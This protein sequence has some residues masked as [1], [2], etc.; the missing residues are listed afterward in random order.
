MLTAS[1]VTY[2]KLTVMCA[3]GQSFTFHRLSSFMNLL[4]DTITH[5]DKKTTKISAQLK[6][7]K[8]HLL[9]Q[10]VRGASLI[11]CHYCSVIHIFDCL[12]AGNLQRVFPSA[13][14]LPRRHTQ[15]GSAHNGLVLLVKKPRDFGRTIRSPTHSP[16]KLHSP[17]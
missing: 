6:E 1:V 2:S 7:T 11:Q 8:V 4:Q 3:E 16:K 9:T 12:S 5:K 17:V 10:S 15:L 14:W 13:R